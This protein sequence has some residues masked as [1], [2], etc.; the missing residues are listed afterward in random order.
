MR[1]DRCQLI[2]PAVLLCCALTSDRIPATD[3]HVYFLG[4]Q[5]NMDGFGRVDELPDELR[6]PVEGVPIFHGS[7]APD[8]V[9]VDGRGIWATLQPGHGYEFSSDGEGNRRSQRFGVEITFARRL[10]ELQPNRHIALIKYS[11]GGT[12]LEV[13]AAGNFGCWDPDFTG[14]EG[15]GQ[16]VNQYD[17]CLATIRQATAARDIDGDGTED[18]LI[19]AG[20]LWMQ[21]ES[22]AAYTPEIAARYQQNLKRMMDL[23]RAALRS[24]DLPVVIGRISDSGR[25]DKDGKVWDHGEVVR[26]AQAEFVKDDGHAALVTSTDDYDYSDPWH[27]DTSGYIDLG[28]KFAEALVGIGAQ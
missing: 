9:A 28:H 11:R 14:G 10:S 15:A 22:D 18:R 12:S 17:H 23:I 6:G 20:I 27:Y 25:D 16:G 7:P 5:S 2:I 24:D 13:G 3:Y 4:G 26:A 19:P 8:G 1:V 21:G